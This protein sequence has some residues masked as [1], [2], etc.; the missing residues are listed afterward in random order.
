MK[1]SN[2]SFLRFE[3]YML[4]QNEFELLCNMLKNKYGKH[5]KHIDFSS[6]KLMKNTGVMSSFSKKLN[7]LLV[8]AECFKDNQTLE[9]LSFEDVS[10]SEKEVVSLCEILKQTNIVVDIKFS[11][12][13]KEEQI[14]KMNQLLEQDAKTKRLKIEEKIKKDQL[15]LY[16]RFSEELQKNIVELVRTLIAYKNMETFDASDASF[17][18]VGFMQRFTPFKQMQYIPGLST[19]VN[20]PMIQSVQKSVDLGHINLKVLVP[21]LLQLESGEMEKAPL[22]TIQ[23]LKKLTIDPDVKKLNSEE[24]GLFESPT[25]AP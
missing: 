15:K 17:L 14:T 21:I 23:L 19:D 9:R 8:V 7:L 16:E 11:S 22:L 10:I 24:R 3:N 6:C 12:D 20:D 4:S 13:V 18:I 2:I 5:I 25:P 1:D